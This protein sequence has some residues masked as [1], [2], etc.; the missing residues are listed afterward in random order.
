M[1]APIL[2]GI[3]LGILVC[4]SASAAPKIAIFSEDGFPYYMANEADSPRLFQ[5]LYRGMGLQAELVDAATVADPAKFNVREYAAYV[6]PYGNT[7]PIEAFANLAK[8]HSEGGIMV[9]PSGV[10]FCHPTTRRGAA[11]WG[12]AAGGE[13]GRLTGAAHSGSACLRI[14]NTLLE[15]WT[16]PAS[17]RMAVKPGDKF[18]VG[19]WAKLERDIAPHEKS[20]ICLR[21]FDATGQFCG[22]DG[23][24][25]PAKAGDWVQLQK[26]VTAPPTAATMDVSPQLWS[27]NATILLD[28]LSLTPAAGGDNLLANPSFEQASGDWVDL[29][30]D[31]THLT[32]E[33][34]IGM[35]SF[36]TQD[37]PADFVLSD[38]GRKIG[39]GAV[40]WSLLPGPAMVQTLD[41][42]S[43]PPGD[44]MIPLVSAGAPQKGFHPAAIVR[45]HCA[46]FNGA[47]DVWGRGNCGTI[48]QRAM[49]QIAM[50]ST[51]A[52]L[53]MKGLISD[54]EAATMVAKANA[55]VPGNERVYQPVTERRP[56]DTPWPHSTKPAE[57]ILVCDVSEAAP[58]Q[59]FQLAVL[60]GLVNR[61]QPRLYL[62]HSRY[63]RQDRQWLDEL[64]L[65]GLKPREVKVDEVLRTFAAVP[66]GRVV[67]DRAILKEIGAFHADRLNLTNIVLMLCAV[68]DA[69][70]EAVTG[71]AAP[72]AGLPVVFDTRGKWQTPGDMYAWAYDRLWPR[73]NHQILGT[74][75]PGIF[76][77]TDYFVQHKVFT[78][79]FPSQRTLKEQELLE[80]VLASTPPNT[81]ILGWWFDWMPNVQDPARAAADCV[82]EGEGVRLGSMFGKFLTA[83]HE[84]T[85]LSLL[86]GMPLQGLKHKPISH[87]AK[88]DR[89]R[90]YFTFLMSDGD[91]LG[92][93]LMMRTRDMHWA[94]S[95]AGSVPIG[96]SFAP[97]TA[98][99]APPV[100]NYYLR[101]ATEADYLVG[102]LGIGYTQPDAYALAFPKQR[103]AIYAQYARMTA[104]SLAPLD[105]DALW[106]I[107]GSKSNVS[108]Y[109]SAGAPLRSIFPDYG[110]G[111]K[112][113]YAAVTYTDQKGV[114]VYRAVTGWGGEGDY[115][116]RLVDELKAASDGARPAF[117][118]AFLLNWGTTIPLLQDVMKKL[119]PEYVCVRPDELDRLYRESKR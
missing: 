112:R 97:A 22:Q 43:L 82:G 54:K 21:F 84:A 108:R 101:T 20:V 113:P 16:G 38:F 78:F 7:F 83:S 15:N 14:H 66:K 60:Q 89:T 87:P 53:A 81:P 67:Y 9:L 41:K 77:I 44:E 114:N 95:R 35:G 98:V 8:Y 74:L 58:E 92:E 63:A 70:P 30:H 107:N 75:Y 93:A 50:K 76:Y 103:D 88:L 1:R 36:L 73:M 29:G 52:A 91:N 100:V 6:H 33:K 118:Q 4:V 40:D 12:M 25:F 90:V 13:N 119:G 115:G 110:T 55:A 106:L 18:T 17:A 109:A 2:F 34:G 80:H 65:E 116:T 46:Q 48:T 79:W 86:S 37:A 111:G 24:A 19:G 27:T 31:G 96:W 56:F 71:D 45:H 105:T 42:A 11:G 51:V 62:V 32:H 26:G 61:T 64:V 85:N 72:P 10:P 23:P 68:N 69:I 49:L 94:A 117:V 99:L 59:Q 57:S 28:D 39:L 3:L 47:I 5:E 102:G 104:D